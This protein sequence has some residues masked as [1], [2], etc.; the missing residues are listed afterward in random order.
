MNSHLH[1]PSSE[2]TSS[3]IEEDLPPQQQQITEENTMD[4]L[5]TALTFKILTHNM[6]CHY[7][8]KAPNKVHRMH[9]FVRDVSTQNYDVVLLQELFVINILGIVA[10]GELRKYMSDEFRNLGYEYQALGTPPPYPY[11]PL[12]FG[13]TR[14]LLPY[15]PL[16]STIRFLTSNRP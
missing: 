13:V 1:N 9:N 12:L 6:W 10:G 3:T 16:L 14:A 11:F 8:T 4:S 15:P 7:L 5:T 2:G